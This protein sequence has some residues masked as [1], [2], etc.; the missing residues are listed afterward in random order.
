MTVF[1]QGCNLRCLA[2]HNPE[3]IGRCAACGSCVEGCPAQA[4]RAGPRI[5]HDATRCQDCGACEAACP[6]SASPRSFPLSVAELLC[7]YQMWAPFLDG[8]TFSG[9]ECSLQADFILEAAAAFKAQ[10][11]SVLVDTNGLMPPATLEALGKGTDG[12]LFDFKSLDPSAHR[13]LTG[14]ENPIILANLERALNLDRVVEVR[15]LIIPGHTDSPKVLDDMV[16]WIRERNP[17]TPIRLNAFRSLGVRGKGAEL[18][19]TTSETMAHLRRRIEALS[20]PA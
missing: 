3:T 16:H 8:L 6:R 7:R 12:F 20:G 15:I 1:L 4:L 9:G 2:C 17:S 14:E 10:G 5:H 18:H 19:E 13:Y 11:F